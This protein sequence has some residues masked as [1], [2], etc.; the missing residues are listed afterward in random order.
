M[1]EDPVGE[2]VPVTEAVMVDN[3]GPWRVVQKES[4]EILGGLQ[5]HCEDYKWHTTKHA[6]NKHRKELP[7]LLKG[8][9]LNVKYVGWKR[10]Y[11]LNNSHH[12][13]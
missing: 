3:L 8:R 6:N 11:A 5:I 4:L 7:L 1:D 2:S 12:Y 13:C 9:R 10:A